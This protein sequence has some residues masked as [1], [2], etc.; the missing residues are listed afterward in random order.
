ML[1]LAV[2]H[3]YARHLFCVAGCYAGENVQHR[4][5]HVALG[6]F[7]RV[8]IE[9]RAVGYSILIPVRILV[10]NNNIPRLQEL[11]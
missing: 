2:A 4:T 5:D 7:Y 9:Y 11:R 6:I 8:R 3:A 1:M 10:Q